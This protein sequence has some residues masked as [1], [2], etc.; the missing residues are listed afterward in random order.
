[1]DILK[2]QLDIVLSI[3][4]QL[5][6]LEQGVVLNNLNRSFLSRQD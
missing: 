4:L 2:I 5:I 6:L 3:P 1:V